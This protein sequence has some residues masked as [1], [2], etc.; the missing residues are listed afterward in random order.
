VTTTTPAYCPWCGRAPH[1][2]TN[3][4]R[5]T[6]RRHGSAIHSALELHVG[7]SLTV[8][9]GPLEVNLFC[10]DCKRTVITA[11]SQGRWRG[12]YEI[13]KCRTE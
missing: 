10:A 7:H 11:G 1:P 12:E 2:I 13:A 8:Q 3:V 6:E 9:P 5:Y 4:L